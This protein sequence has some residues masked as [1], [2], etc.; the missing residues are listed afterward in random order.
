[1]T[2]RKFLLGKITRNFRGISI[3]VLKKKSDRCFGHFTKPTFNAAGIPSFP[4]STHHSRH[5]WNTR[6]HTHTH[7]L[8]CF[9][10]VFRNKI[11]LL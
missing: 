10:T 8:D 1:M 2:G 11:I 3:L 9:C 4:R 5:K 6:T 7:N